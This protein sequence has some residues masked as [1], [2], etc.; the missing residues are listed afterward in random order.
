M[1]TEP[2]RAFGRCES[3]AITL[4]WTVLAALVL[5]FAVG[6]VGIVAS[7][8]GK[9]GERLGASLT[10]ASLDGSDRQQGGAPAGDDGLLPE[11][12]QPAEPEKPQPDDTAR[13]PQADDAGRPAVPP[14]LERRPEQPPGLDIRPVVPPGLEGRQLPPAAPL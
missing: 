13:P 14:G 1:A 7:G 10:A 4:D 9:Y 2:V 3:G 5:G 6:V 12:P 11:T 8:A